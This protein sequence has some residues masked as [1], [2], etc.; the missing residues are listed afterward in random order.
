VPVELLVHD[1]VPR[2]NHL[3]GVDNHDVIAAVEMWREIWLVL[4]AQ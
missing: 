2:Q 1:L 4:A 3:G